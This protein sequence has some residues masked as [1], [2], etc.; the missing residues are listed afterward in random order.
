MIETAFNGLFQ[1]KLHM[2]KA[3]QRVGQGEVVFFMIVPG[4][5]T[6]WS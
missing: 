1:G 4:K 2:Y 6:V 5:Q 3:R